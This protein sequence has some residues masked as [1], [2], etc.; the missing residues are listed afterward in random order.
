MRRHPTFSQQVLEDIPALEEMAL[1]IGAHH[2]RPDG[3]GYPEMLDGE[4]IPLEARIIGVADTYVALTSTRPYR[5]ALSD[6]DAQ[7]VLLGGAGTQLDKK[8][9]QLFC[10]ANVAA[11]PAGATSSR[12][13]PPAA[14]RR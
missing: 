14:R 6:E 13:A 1:W 4:T 7:Q 5:R 8:L 10:S 9:V 2:E 3:K 12:S 11:A